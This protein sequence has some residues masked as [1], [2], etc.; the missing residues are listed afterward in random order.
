MTN[1]DILEGLTEREVHVAKVAAKLAVKE[2]QDEVYRGIGKNV[3]QRFLIYVGII[4]VSVAF[5]KG[6]LSTLLK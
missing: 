2:M 5:G 6:W 3:V 1:E 4:A